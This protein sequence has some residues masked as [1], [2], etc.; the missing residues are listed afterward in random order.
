MRGQYRVLIFASLA[1]LAS[2]ACGSTITIMASEKWAQVLGIALTSI[3][4]AVLF[5][6]AVSYFY[7]KL[8][9][10]WF[11]DEVWRIF[12][13][14]S[15]AGVIR[16]FRDREFYRGRD[17]AQERLSEA[18][19]VHSTGDVLIMGPTLR[20]FFNPL[21]PFYE[22]VGAMVE[23]GGT[24]GYKVRALIQRDDSPSALDRVAAEQPDL[25]P[26][27]ASHASHDAA[28]TVDRIGSLGV[29][30][31]NTIE[32]RRF[33][34]APYCTAI[35]FPD[36]AYYSPNLLSSSVPVKMPMILFRSESHGYRMLVE[37]FEYLWKLDSTTRS[38]APPAVSAAGGTAET[39]TAPPP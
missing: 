18:F 35:I 25:R 4:A 20:V 34:P 15:D 3:G 19:R 12:T 24:S 1:A 7:D 27:Q 37:M 30:F 31:A 14:L 10:R 26:G 32:V 9:E 28:Q 33:M 6:I 36:V 39:A 8:R 2:F 38:A 21:G 23:R 11:G 5:P 29:R 16:I 22:V 17:N 13:E